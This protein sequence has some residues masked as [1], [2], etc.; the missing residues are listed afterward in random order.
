M[1]KEATSCKAE[2]LKCMHTILGIRRHVQMLQS[3][4]RFGEDVAACK[5]SRNV[6]LLQFTPS[7]SSVPPLALRLVAFNMASLPVTL[8]GLIC[9]AQ[10][11]F[12]SSIRLSA[13]EFI[14]KLF[15]DPVHFFKV[16]LRTVLMSDP[17]ILL[18]FR[19][20]KDFLQLM[21]QEL[22]RVLAVLSTRKRAIGDFNPNLSQQLSDSS[23]GDEAEFCLKLSQG[24]ELVCKS[25][26]SPASSEI[27]RKMHLVMHE[28]GLHDATSAAVDSILSTCAPIEIHEASQLTPRLR[29]VTPRPLSGDAAFTELHV[30]IVAAISRVISS[31]CVQNRSVQAFFF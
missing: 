15:L 16:A 23:S 24:A 27:L 3:L 11:S 21:A 31:I 12:Q 13:L 8:T 28:L 5:V 4:K 14:V 29:R 19:S 17:S 22:P 1:Q 25:L 20:V 10:S 7:A 26:S 6:D 9:Q 30:K 18:C 2:A